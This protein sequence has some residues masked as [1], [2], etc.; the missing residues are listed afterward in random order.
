[1]LPR[2]NKEA[3]AGGHRPPRQYVQ[4]VQYQQDPAEEFAVQYQVM[5]QSQ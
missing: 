1:M 2:E 3:D 4:Y 5:W